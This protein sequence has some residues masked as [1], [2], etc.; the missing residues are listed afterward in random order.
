MTRLIG[1]AGQTIR[2]W[3]LDA[4]GAPLTGQVAA[5][6]VA[7]YQRGINAA[8]VPITLSDLTAVTDA[9]SEG[10]VLELDA[11]DA[12]GAYRL[13][14]PNAMLA[15]GVDLVWLFLLVD[16]V[17]QAPMEFELVGQ[18]TVANGAVNTNV[19]HFGGTAGSF[20]SG[21]PEV[22]TSHWGGTAVASAVILAAA[23]IA[24]DAFSAVKFAADAITKIWSNGTRTLTAGDNIVLAKG[25]GVTGFNDL[26]AAGMRTALGLTTNNLTTLLT[27]ISS[28]ID[29]LETASAAGQ[30]VINNNVLLV[31]AR[32]IGLAVKTGTIVA[33]VGN[34]ATQLKTDLSETT[35]NHW[36]NGWILITSG[37]MLGATAPITGYNG[38]TKVL[39]FTAENQ[40]L[41]G[42][43]DNGV[44]FSIINR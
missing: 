2:F 16:G 3:A 20:S 23:N 27:N 11:T 36:R 29:D 24:T 28:A 40:P 15:T 7:H 32:I 4:A 17:P 42:I 13:D 12:P 43:A 9:F 39:S 22:N 31:I 33:D 1:V 18:V 30:T 8:L 21:R 5:D 41:P 37:T 10:G 6:I 34:S 14:P 19:T 44:T 35:S 26:D 38:T 25:T